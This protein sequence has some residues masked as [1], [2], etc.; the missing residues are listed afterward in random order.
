MSLEKTLEL[1]KKK[2]D[3][4]KKQD[5]SFLETIDK[6]IDKIRD[7]IAFFR[8]YPDLFIDYI[9]GEDSKFKFYTYQRIFLRVAIRHRRIYA[10][11]PRA[12]S[13]S[14][15]SMMILMIRCILYPNSEL[16]IT[17]GR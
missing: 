1:Y 9:K 12:F 14:F 2:S 4:T 11:F 7:T 17:T 10:T 15:L 16:F 13:K 3:G 8:Q 6:D 5:L